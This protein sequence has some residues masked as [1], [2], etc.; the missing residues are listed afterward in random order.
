MVKIKNSQ[1]ILSAE[2]SQSNWRIGAV[3]TVNQ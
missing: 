3:N 1:Q 2:E